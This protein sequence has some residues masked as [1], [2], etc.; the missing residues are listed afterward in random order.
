MLQ[1]SQ[2]Q[3]PLMPTEVPSRPFEHVSADFFSV[4]GKSFLVYADRLLGWPVVVMCGCDTT[5]SAAIAFF[6]R[7]FRDLGVPVQLRTD[8]GPQFTS[9]D[10]SD[11]LRR[12]GVC[13]EVSSPYYL[14]SNSHAE[15]VVKSVKHLV[16]KTAHSDT[17]TKDF[18]HGLLELR[19]TP[20]QD[21][22]SPV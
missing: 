1:P 13:H 5:T 11:F 8:R 4:A 3:E 18:D 6:R 2:Q 21:G 17:L 14:Q 15:A 9:R 10:F 12:W 16:M 19:N 20:R 22:C 7:F